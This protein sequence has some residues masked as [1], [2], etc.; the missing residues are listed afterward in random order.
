MLTIEFNFTMSVQHLMDNDV[1]FR[2]W[3]D[4]ED[5]VTEEKPERYFEIKTKPNARDTALQPERYAKLVKYGANSEQAE[6]CSKDHQAY[7]AMLIYL[8][9]K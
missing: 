9:G 1:I 2:N 7:M 3:E 5:T 4:D 8:K 6:Q